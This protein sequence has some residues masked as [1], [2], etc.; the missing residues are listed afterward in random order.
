MDNVQENIASKPVVKFAN[1]AFKVLRKIEAQIVRFNRMSF[2]ELKK[3]QAANRYSSF[4]HLT[5]PSGKYLPYGEIGN[6]CFNEL[7]ELILKYDAGLKGKFSF[8]LTKKTLQSIFVDFFVKDL[9][10]VERESCEP[11]F[12]KVICAMVST[13]REFE[14]H[15]PC[16]FFVFDSPDT[17]WIGPVKFTKT[18][19]FLQVFKNSL[20]EDSQG[21]T[22]STLDYYE[23]RSMEY[24]REF[25][26]VASVK[27][28]QC[29]FE[30][31]YEWA[32]FHCNTALNVTRV[33]FGA[34]STKWVRLGYDLG[35]PL[36]SAK[37]WSEDS[38][39]KCSIA[40]RVRAPTG[41]TNWYDFLNNEA[42]EIKHILG[43]VISHTS[44]FGQYSELSNRLLD[45]VNWFGDAAKES[46]P[47][48]SVL[49]YVTAIE[50]LYFGSFSSSFKKRFVSRVSKVLVDFEC[51]CASGSDSVLNEVYEA[52]STLVHGAVS[53]SLGDV[54]WPNWKA[55]EIASQCI[56][57]AIQLYGLFSETLYPQ[58]SQEL[59]ECFLQYEEKGIEW[60][61]L[62]VERKR[63]DAKFSR[64]A[65]C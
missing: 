65:E 11:Y 36:S 14:H 22:L 10:A 40:S 48:A 51:H 57:C 42:L 56:F 29:D 52:R 5:S 28:G 59:E 25:P 45:A 39:I 55:E 12:I 34:N 35:S 15:V 3:Y 58:S 4:Y 19:V 41:P 6:D 2:E 27:V 1:Y 7:C 20:N 44:K 61:M 63:H 38:K 13:A 49:K 31:S 21:E 33:L 26:W 30:T 16:N 8:D 9:K 18:E 62:E 47:A 53:P 54:M 43:S 17:F 64:E 46:S 23:G 37:I 32:L 24:Y 60:F 50:R